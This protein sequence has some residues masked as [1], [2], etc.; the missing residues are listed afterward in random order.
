MSADF[1]VVSMEAPGTRS[2]LLFLSGDLEEKLRLPEAFLCFRYRCVTSL[3]AA[4]VF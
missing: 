4:H 2:T 3:W 1:L